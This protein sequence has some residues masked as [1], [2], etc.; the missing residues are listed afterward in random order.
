[1]SLPL[2][3]SRADAKGRITLGP[4]EAGHEFAITREEKGFRLE[5]VRTM[6]YPADEAW[7][8]EDAEVIEQLKQGIIESRQGKV[9]SLDEL[10]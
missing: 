8:W 10:D 9:A 4:E 5:L 3:T 2:K 6:V 1:M 7:I